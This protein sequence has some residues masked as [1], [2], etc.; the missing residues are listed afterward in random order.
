M[1]K[2][3]SRAGVFCFFF[4][5]KLVFGCVW[6]FFFVFFCLEGVGRGSVRGKSRRSPKREVLPCRA[7]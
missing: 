2:A 5:L 3:P 7:G 4:F 6:G 1:G